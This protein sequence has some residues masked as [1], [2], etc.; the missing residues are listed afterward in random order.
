MSFELV[1]TLLRENA[2]QDVSR[3]VTRGNGC[4]RARL[5][6]RVD[7]RG[8]GRLLPA[9]SQ[10]YAGR[11]SRRLTL[12]VGTKASNRGKGTTMLSSIP[13]DIRY[14]LR[15]LAKSPT[16]SAIAI[17]TL[18]IGIAANTVI[19]SVVNGVLLNPL[20]HP[21]ANQLVILWETDQRTNPPGT[22]ILMA[23]PGI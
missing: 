3:P 16:F 12:G 8:A 1:P 11:C 2:R 18:T 15:N 13:Q 17:L 4:V 5:R 10:S 20:H 9:R 21:D 19:F 14:A 7:A 23:P 22:R 6:D